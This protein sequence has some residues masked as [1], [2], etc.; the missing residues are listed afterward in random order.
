MK[1]DF[2]VS[3]NTLSGNLR[4][5]THGLKDMFMGE[6]T[7]IREEFK[8]EI[9]AIHQTIEDL[10]AD[11]ASCKRSLASGG[12]NTSNHGPKFGYQDDGPMLEGYHDVMVE[13][14]IWIY[15]VRKVREK[16]SDQQKVDHAC[17]TT[18]RKGEKF[19]K[20]LTESVGCIHS[21]EPLDSRLPK[22]T[23]LHGKTQL[24]KTKRTSNDDAWY[25]IMIFKCNQVRT[26]G[27][28]GCR[29]RPT[30]Q[31][32]N[33]SRCYEV[34]PI[35]G[36]AKDVREKIGE[37]EGTI[38]LSVVPLD[39][40]K[41]VLGLEFIDKVRAFP[42]PFANSL[43]II[44]GGKT[45]MVSIQCD[46]KSGVKTLFTMKF[47]KAFNKREPCYLAVTRLE[48]EEGSRK[49]E[50]PKV[51]EQVLDEFKD[52]MP[53][54]LP[55]KSPPM[56]EKDGSLRKCIDYRALNKVTIKNKYIIPLIADL[57]DQLGKAR[58]FNKLDLRS[59]YY[60]VRIA[61]GDEAKMT[62]V[63][64]YGYYK[65]LV[66][67]FGLTIAPVTFCTL[68]NKLFH[69]FLDK[70]MVV[71]Q[72]NKLYLKLE[73][74]SFAQDEVMFL[75][76]KIKDGGLMIEVNYYR[77][78]IMGYSAIASP[79]T[80]LLK[81]NKAWI[82]DEEFQAAFESLKKAVMEEPLL[83]LPDVTMP[84]ELHTDA[85]DR[86]RDPESQASS[87]AKRLSRVR[88][89]IGV[90][91]GEVNNEVD[92]ALSRKAKFAAI[93]QAQF[94]LHDRIKEGLEHDPLAKE[95]IVLVKDT[96]TRR[97]W[98]KGD[99][100]FTKGDWLY[101]PKWG[102]LKR[103][104]YRVQLQP[105]LKIHSV[106]NVSFLTPYHGDEEYPEREVFEWATTAVVTSLYYTRL[107]DLVEFYGK[108][109][110]VLEVLRRSWNPLETLDA[111]TMEG[112]RI[113]ALPL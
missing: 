89:P 8:E 39:Y 16:K 10:Q 25:R 54:E 79:L 32:N 37:W 99:M 103:V 77:R 75:G 62:C 86:I 3:L 22:E 104:S 51:I 71:L 43:C 47:K 23:R 58:Y 101:V 97:F 98:L 5:E 24:L 27:A 66:M 30:I 48:T 7:K 91:D 73:K 59:G 21:D 13:T 44:N 19:K 53:K 110:K 20:S 67:P 31:G 68:M 15:Q 70:F 49:V 14:S 61:E 107:E 40:F 12:D 63:T 108:C 41:V 72:D 2:R 95:I 81:K 65:F 106:F 93:T 6:I 80:D 17:K 9:S 35:H 96:K 76:C 57:F 113:W 11:V 92:D 18:H 45:F 36:V 56:R 102:D 46:A 111:S 109:K 78:F 88:P 50:V 29:E 74:C 84:F 83:R 94:F 85:S 90:Q 1:D 87:L 33:P 64:M 42:I 69:L 26:E 55:K 38:D 105:K 100:L 4:H 52:V 82:W 112:Y 60:Q 28:N 34:K